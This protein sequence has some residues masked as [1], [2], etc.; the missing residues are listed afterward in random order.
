MFPFLKKGFK[1]KID[2]NDQKKPF[3]SSK[4]AKIVSDFFKEIISNYL[5]IDKKIINHVDHHT[6]H[7]AYAFFG[8]PIRHKNSTIFT[9][10]LDLPK[11]IVEII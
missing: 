3:Q 10:S 4:D 1:H 11:R 6:C 2:Q 7:A 8:S 5:K 9:K